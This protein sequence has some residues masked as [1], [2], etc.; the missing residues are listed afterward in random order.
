MTQKFYSI[1]FGANGYF[2][3][4]TQGGQPIWTP[5]FDSI[6]YFGTKEELLAVADDLYAKG[7]TFDVMSYDERVA[8]TIIASQYQS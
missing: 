1:K 7:Y 8:S 5:K 4:Y 2:S 3:N 6:R